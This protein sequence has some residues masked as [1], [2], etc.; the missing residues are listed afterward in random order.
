M[1]RLWLVAGAIALSVSSGAAQDAQTGPPLTL[2]QPEGAAGPPK[3]VT[4]QDALDR[5]R[6]TDAQFQAAFAEAAVAREDRVQA[7]ASLL[8][9]LSYTTQYLGNSPTPDNINPNGRFVSLDGVKMYRAW[10][11]AHQELSPNVLMRTPLRRAAAA[12]AA[13]EARLEVAQ[14]GLA[15]TVT[16]SYYAFVVAQ[17]RYAGAQLSAQQASRFFET[18]QQQ[19]RLGQVAR[20]DVIKAE[21]QYQQQQQAYRDALVA[22][23]NARLALAVLLSPTLDENFAVVD[24]LA[25]APPLPPFADVRGMASRNNP[26]VRA[27]DEA[28]R[29]A[30]QDVRAAKNAFL[31]NVVVDAVYGIEA[32]EF[33]LHSR[34]AAQPELGVLPNLGYFITV[35]LS[36]PVWDWGG[37]RSKLHQSEARQHQAEV[38][39]TLAQR[40]V[41]SNLFSMY[42]EAIAAKSGVDNLQHVAD[43]AA[44]SLRLTTLRYQA[45]ESTALE[46]VDAQNTFVQ[47][48]TA[49]DDAQVRYRVALAQLQTLTGR[50]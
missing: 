5:A 40:Q 38:A 20:S 22:M 4:L 21:I 8:P 45:G 6:E 2:V 29:A 25:A 36:V 24:D 46:V 35:N 10:G 47:A 26:D 48:R 42:N 15:V 28:L 32:N 33:A 44:E 31:P 41:M 49:F 43:L 30:G 11:V 12:E 16:R 50:F 17:R 37:L 27:A 23:E 34:I 19:Q 39:L 13:A 18:T 3:T 14:R 1:L 7:R 9:S